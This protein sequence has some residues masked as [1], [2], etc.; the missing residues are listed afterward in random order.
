M[1]QQREKLTEMMKKMRG[2]IPKEMQ[3]GSDE[4]EDD[5]D[6]PG[7]ENPEGQTPK[8]QQQRIGG[9]REIDPD[10]LRVLK[11]KM[12]QRTMSVGQEGETGEREMKGFRPDGQKPGDPK[13]RKGRDW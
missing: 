6:E 10:M 3:R 13:G 11:E 2:K 7:D 8:Q 4:E 9:E 12:P 1:G 5:E